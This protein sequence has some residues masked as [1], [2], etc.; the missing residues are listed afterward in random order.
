MNNQLIGQDSQASAG[1]IGLGDSY[2]PGLGNGGYDVQHYTLDFNVIDVETSLLDATATLEVQATQDLSSFNLDFSGF[3]I[4]SITV[5]GE[6]AGFS[7]DGDELTITPTELLNQGDDFTVE[8]K[9]KGSPESTT[10]ISFTDRDFD[11]PTGWVTFDGGSYALSEPNGSET[12]YPLNNH[13]LDKATYTFR[14]TTPEPYEV[15]ANGILEETID[16]GDTNTYVFEARDPMAGYLST[17]N[18]YDDFTEEMQT[19]ANGILVRNY[20][21]DEIPEEQLEPFDRQPEMI[22]Y[23][24]EIFGPYPFEVYGSVVVNTEIGAGALETQTLSIYGLEAANSSILEDIIAH[25]LVHQWFGNSLALTDWS[26]IWLNE[27]FASYGEGLWIEESQGGSEALDNWLKEQ[28]TDVAINFD[29]YS[30]PGNPPPGDL[31]NGGVYIWGGLGLHALRQEIGDDAFFDS[32]RTYTSRFENG[33]VTPEDFIAINEE[34]SNQELNPLFDRWFYSEEL[35]SFP[36]LGLFAGTLD[37]DMLLGTDADEVLSGLDGDDTLVGNGGDNT[38]VGNSGNDLL[39][40]GGD[41]DIFD[42][43]SGTLNGLDGNDF[44]TGGDGNDRFIIASEGTD[45]IT[46][47]TQDEDFLELPETISFADLEIVQGQGEDTDNTFINFE[48]ETLAILNDIDAAEISQSDFEMDITPPEPQFGTVDGDVLEINSAGQFVFVG[49][50]ND[51]IDATASKGDNRIYTGSGDDT[52]I[53]GAGDRGFSGEGEDRFFASSG[54]D[55]TLT[56]GEG[57]DQFWI[58]VAEIPNS[59]NTVTD[60]DL[61]EDVI[62]IAGLGIGFSDLNL[63]Q[64][65]EDVLIQAEDNDLAIFQGITTDSLSANNF[66]FT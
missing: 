53:L 33:N 61:T 30:T 50:G 3:E 42:P 60:Y 17:I 24:S 48:S 59:P 1:S 20:F 22:D 58:A 5:N 4:E 66:V 47:F 18:I 15:A 65:E 54:G 57:A 34:V 28:F 21:A 40:G 16:N 55:N 26:D 43:G 64:Q 13:P 39:Y 31:F 46:D 44:L 6:L 19:S 8:V 62:G 2:Y 63:I 36:E 10:S 27:S 29:N 11:L 49:D 23:F 9:Y 12:Y 35:A 51:L 52:L 7:R 14:V 25:E 45:T 32:L 56:G 38:L 37:N 41:L